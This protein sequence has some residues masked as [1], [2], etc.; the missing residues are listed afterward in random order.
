MRRQAGDLGAFG[1]LDAVDALIAEIEP[2]GKGIAG[3]ARCI[4]CGWAAAGFNVDDQFA[5]RWTG[6]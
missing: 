1:G 5:T 3:A 6:W 4:T 2:D